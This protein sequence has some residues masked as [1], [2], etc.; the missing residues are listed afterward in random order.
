VGRDPKAFR[1]AV[2]VRLFNGN[3]LSEIPRFVDVAAVFDGEMVGEE[4]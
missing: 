3:A 2:L 4:L 1:F